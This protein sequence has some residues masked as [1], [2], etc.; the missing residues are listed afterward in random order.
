MER[1]S[2]ASYEQMKHL[3]AKI[4]ELDVDKEIMWKQRSRMDWLSKGDNNMKFF[5]LFNSTHRCKN[6]LTR[7]YDETGVWVDDRVQLEKVV[8][9]YFS[10]SFTSS[11][12]PI[13]DAVTGLVHAKLSN[14]ERDRLRE[15]YIAKEVH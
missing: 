8:H 6:K 10:K 2:E 9:D 15:P 4:D 11:N 7:L 12:P 5:R 14:A 3:K 13:E 1:A